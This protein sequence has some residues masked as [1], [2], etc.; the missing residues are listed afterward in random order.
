MTE[1]SL[2]KTDKPRPPP[3]S[4]S[5]LRLVVSLLNQMYHKQLMAGDPADVTPAQPKLSAQMRNDLTK[6]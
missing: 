4:G 1:T 6:I 5:E 2:D 3:V